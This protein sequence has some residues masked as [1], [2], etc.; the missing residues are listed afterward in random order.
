MIPW[1]EVM[2]AFQFCH[3]GDLAAL[4]PVSLKVL[5]LWS[6]DLLSVQDFI[7]LFGL[8]DSSNIGIGECMVQYLSWPS[9]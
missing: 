8:P 9:A 6:R 2:H 1:N 4:H 5:A 3:G 7:R